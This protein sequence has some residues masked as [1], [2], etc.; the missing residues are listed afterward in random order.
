MLTWT[1]AHQKA[2]AITG[3]DSTTALVLLKSDINQG[4]RRFNAAMNRYFTRRAKVTNIV[5]G[6][7]YYQVSPDCIRVIKVRASQSTTGTVKYPVRQVRS[8]Q[9]WDAL[10]TVQQ[11]G[12]WATYYFV[13]GSD[14]IG[15]WPIPSSD[16]TN[17]L[18]I[19]YE[20]RDKEFSQEDYTTGTVTLTNGSATVTGSSTVFTESM[21]GRGFKTTDG[22]DGYT[23]KVAGYASGTSITLE[24]PYIGLSNSGITYKIGETFLFPEEYHDAPV[25]YAVARYFEQRN[26]Q[27][28]AM[29]HMARFESALKEARE[30]YASSS[31]SAII[32]DRNEAINWWLIPP[33]PVT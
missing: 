29:Y 2:Q 16:I 28:R 1:E 14:E 11:E 24:E 22:S 8:E 13:R 17:G 20:P 33:E 9:E 21:I 31:Q 15:I 6:Q 12:N 19:S 7:Q 10:N 32:T 5:D 30:K 23:Y 18:E 4:Y 25:D 27:E 3:D 26:Q